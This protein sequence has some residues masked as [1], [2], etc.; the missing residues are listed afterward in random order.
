MYDDP[1]DPDLMIR[2]AAPTVSENRSMLAALE[3]AWW[4]MARPD[5][6]PLRRNVSALTLGNALPYGFIAERIAPGH[7]RFRVAGRKISDM[8]GCEARGMPLSCLFNAPARETFA[9]ILQQV[10][11]GPSVADLPLEAPRGFGRARL[12]GRMLIL[13]LASD[14]CTVDRALGAVVLD[15]PIAGN[16]RRCDIPKGAKSRLDPVTTR[17]SILTGIDGGASLSQTPRAVKPTLRLVVDN[18]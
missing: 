11:D 8:M 1:N 4:G 6:V 18:S 7:A 3:N 9:E 15:G 2:P 13:P 17:R 16:I 14:D 10:F 12:G 5:G